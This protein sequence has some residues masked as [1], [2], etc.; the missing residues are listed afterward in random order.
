RLRRVERELHI[1]HQEAEKARRLKEQFAANVS[2]ELR[3]PLN[4]IY[5][6]SEMMHRSPAVYGELAWPANLRR[7]IY[8]IYRS[9]RHL[10]SM[11]DDILALSRFEHADFVLDQE[12]TDLAELL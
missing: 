5:G 6:F 7:D 10:L 9:S 2:H 1:A 3:T 12:P 4:L 11:I 8:Q